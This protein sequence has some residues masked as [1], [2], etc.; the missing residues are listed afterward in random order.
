[1]GVCSSLPVASAK[2]AASEIYQR[3]YKT[4]G[5]FAANA[6]TPPEEKARAKQAL[7]D[8]DK[9]HIQTLDSYSSTVVRQ[10]ANR[11][12][13][14][15]NFTVAEVENLKA[16]AFR[17]LVNHKDE[18]ALLAVA[19]PGNLHKLAEDLFETAISEYTDITCPD[20]FFEKKL[21]IQCRQITEVWNRLISDNANRREKKTEPS[22]E[23]SVV[24]SVRGLLLSRVSWSRSCG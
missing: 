23:D 21:L 17:F 5:E 12:G 10:A 3:I 2:K 16:D 20:D 14:N 18:P 1:M 15:P 4:L 7:K 11:Y 22:I 6:Q 13:I 19:T 8:F 9:A 24:A